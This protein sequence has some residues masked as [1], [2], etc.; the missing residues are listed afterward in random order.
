MTEL[1][2]LMREKLLISQTRGGSVLPLIW[3]G[4]PVIELGES[5]MSLYTGVLVPSISMRGTLS[6]L[7]LRDREGHALGKDCMQTSITG[8][9]APDVCTRFGFH[10]ML[11]YLEHRLGVDEISEGTDVWTLA[12]ARRSYWW[13]EHPSRVI[14]AGL[15]ALHT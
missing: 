14:K 15:R 8:G 3:E 2:A 4:T 13:R 7:W 6:I 12:E 11:D 10:V 5:G 1:R 9:S